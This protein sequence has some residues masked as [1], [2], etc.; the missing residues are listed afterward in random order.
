MELTL[1]EYKIIIDGSYLSAIIEDELVLENEESMANNIV[2]N[3]SLRNVLNHIYENVRY[4][5]I[6]FQEIKILCFK[7]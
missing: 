3:L 6:E 4:E 5:K 7:K 1:P 2:G